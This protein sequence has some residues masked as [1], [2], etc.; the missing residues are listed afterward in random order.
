M[1]L[2]TADLMGFLEKCFVVPKTGEAERLGGPEI[3]DELE[4]G[5]L[6]DRQIG[7]LVVIEAT[8]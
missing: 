8:C 6:H 7:G 4:L 2:V 5:R 3:D 1:R